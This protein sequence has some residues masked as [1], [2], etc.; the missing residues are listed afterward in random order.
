M[1]S[2]KI[3]AVDVAQPGVPSTSIVKP[4][5]L[6]E[7]RLS[8]QFYLVEVSRALLLVDRYDYIRTPTG[9]QYSVNFK[10]LQL[11][12]IKGEF[13]AL[14]IW[15]NQQFSWTVMEQYPLTPPSLS[16]QESSLI[17][18]ILLIVVLSFM[19]SGTKAVENI[20]AFTILKMEN[21]NGFVLDSH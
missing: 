9:G 15:E 20:C 7:Y 6:V 21:L 14:A 11:H 2:G 16:L 10:V 17:I 19:V 13:K 18:F 5:L 3:Y 4:R 8:N 1:L 12:V